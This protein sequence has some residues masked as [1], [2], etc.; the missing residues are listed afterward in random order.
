M[1]FV[2]RS[3]ITQAQHGS[4]GITTLFKNKI[5][6]DPIIVVLVE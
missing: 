1:E 6:F 4:N 2:T 5:N 3:V